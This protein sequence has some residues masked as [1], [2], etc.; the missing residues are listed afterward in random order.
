MFAGSVI[1]ATTFFYLFYHDLS[2]EVGTF[3]DGCYTAWLA[4]AMFVT[5]GLF[6]IVSMS[7]IILPV[8]QGTRPQYVLQS[9]A[10]PDNSKSPKR[11]S[12]NTPTHSPN[13]PRLSKIQFS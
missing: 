9:P 1:C 12:A 6:S 4:G 2:T 10:A 7:S 11:L 3:Q 8:G 13:F 5:F